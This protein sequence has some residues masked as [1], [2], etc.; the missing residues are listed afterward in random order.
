MRGIARRRLVEALGLTGL[1]SLFPVLAAT[2]SAS[3]TQDTSSTA[4]SGLQSRY[5]QYPDCIHAW[6]NNVVG[7]RT[8]RTS[9]DRRSGPLRHGRMQKA[10]GFSTSQWIASVRTPIIAPGSALLS[11]SG[12][13][14]LCCQM[15]DDKGRC[16]RSDLY[17]YLQ[18]GPGLM[19]SSRDMHWSGLATRRASTPRPGARAIALTTVRR[20]MAWQPPCCPTRF[21]GNPPEISPPNV[22][23]C[24]CTSMSRRF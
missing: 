6:P 14:Q 15:D 18:L 12:L 22:L 20:A 13:C 7:T 2:A 4:R 1:A 23:Q 17:R 21:A 5:R 19:F 9:L 8:T 11:K 16:L 24:P 3:S 10:T